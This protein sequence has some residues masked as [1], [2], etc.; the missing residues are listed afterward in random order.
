MT[1]E[2]LRQADK[3]QVLALFDVSQVI[4][5]IHDPEELFSRV[6]DIA[7]SA[8]RAERGFLMIR[9]RQGAL[10][11]M[12]ARNLDQR[13]IENPEEVS[14]TVI[15]Q[16]LD[17]GEP[18]LTSDARTDPR[19]TGSESVR[20][21]NIRS[22]LCAPLVKGG[23]ALGLIFVDSR[24]AANVFSDKDK[25]FLAAFAN[26]AA[27]AIENARLQS[28]LRE[29]NLT[30]KQE[31][32]Q[33][34]RFENL[35]GQSPPFRKAL[36]M[37]EK[38][39]DSEVP[40]LVQGES[41]T[42]KELVA[43]AIHYNGP[44]RDKKF[45]AQYCGALPETLLESELFGY[46][47]GAFTGAMSSKPGLFETAEGGT[48][49]LDEI[50][51]IAPSIQAKLLRVLQDGEMRRIGETSPIRVNVRVISAT[52]RDLLTEVRAGRFREDLFYRLN[53]VTINLPP[54]RERRQDIPLLVE[55]FLESFP[56]ARSRG[57]RQVDREALEKLMAYGWPGNIRELENALSY[58]VV[59]SKGGAIGAKDLPQEVSSREGELQRGFA[60]GRSMRDVERE[61]LLATLKACGNDRKRT[62][63][64]LGI[65][66]RTLQYKLKEYKARS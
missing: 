16:V 53:V 20:L 32:R 46:K 36:A 22:I 65:S 50:G 11:A 43:K 39:L 59:M 2:E 63:Q 35:V 7:V 57:V 44:R 47:K 30:L 4:N 9:D 62:A 51:D 17:S 14:G 42:G 64:Q 34:Y 27:I 1:T 40:V 61:Y 19:F 55:H 25:I 24:T 29:E 8:T 26:I 54:L 49:F 52:N 33:Q 38:V 60:T 45:V 15:Q 66:L 12:A 21:Y 48:F 10:R 23:Q 41:G 3:E 58:G 56:P 28:T 13:D 5:S 6:M 37:V 31:V 18:V